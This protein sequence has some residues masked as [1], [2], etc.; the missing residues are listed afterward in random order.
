MVILAVVLLCFLPLLE[1]IGFCQDL[2]P[3][4]F[5]SIFEHGEEC[6]S[7][8]LLNDSVSSQPDSL[9]HERLSSFQHL[10]LLR[11]GSED[12]AIPGQSYITH[13]RLTP[14]PPPSLR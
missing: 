13:L 12:V 5:P 3:M 6:D 11:P 8:E 7:S 1:E 2:S 9:F 4:A 14:R 10:A